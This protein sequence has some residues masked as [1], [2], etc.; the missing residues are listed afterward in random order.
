MSTN[1]PTR[2]TPGEYHKIGLSPFFDN[3]EGGPR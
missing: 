3:N 1:K 2:C